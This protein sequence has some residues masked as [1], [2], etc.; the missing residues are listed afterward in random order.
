MSDIFNEQK[1]CVQKFIEIKG[2]FQMGFM[3]INSATEPIF[4]TSETNF[5]DYVLIVDTSSNLPKNVLYRNN[6]H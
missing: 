5:S 3:D 2:T 1:A 4:L 6:H